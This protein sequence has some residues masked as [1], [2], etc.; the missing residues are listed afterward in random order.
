[1]SERDTGKVKARNEKRL[2]SGTV[3]VNAREVSP[4]TS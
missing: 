3:V 1:V 2:E 4:W